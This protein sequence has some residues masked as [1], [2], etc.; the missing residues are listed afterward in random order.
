MFYSSN[1]IESKAWISLTVFLIKK[2]KKNEFVWSFTFVYFDYCLDKTDFSG[3]TTISRTRLENPK[4]PCVKLLRTRSGREPRIIRWPLPVTAGGWT[5][6]GPPSAFF[7]RTIDWSGRVNTR[8]YTFKTEC[9][10][11]NRLFYVVKLCCLPLL[12]VLGKDGHQDLTYNFGVRSHYDP[13][14][15]R[16]PGHPDANLAS[17]REVLPQTYP[18]PED[19]THRPVRGLE[20]HV[21]HSG[22]RSPI[23]PRGGDERGRDGKRREGTGGEEG[24]DHGLCSWR[25]HGRRSVCPFPRPRRLRRKSDSVYLP[26]SPRPQMVKTLYSSFSF[27]YSL[28]SDPKTGVSTSLGWVIACTRVVVGGAY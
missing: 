11:N 28:T 27:R 19:V 6:N 17:T 22:V 18:S 20:G 26:R 1:L 3:P 23:Y 16:T 7:D 2:K 5:T 10:I 15:T 25:T 21:D 8:Y 14:R 13:S 4:V 9:R 24:M 12:T